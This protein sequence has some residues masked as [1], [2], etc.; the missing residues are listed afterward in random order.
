MTIVNDEAVFNVA[1]TQANWTAQ[2][3]DPPSTLR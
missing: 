2:D 1:G 3:F